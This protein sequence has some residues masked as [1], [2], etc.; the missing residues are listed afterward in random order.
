M[1]WLFASLSA[2]SSFSLCRLPT[3]TE[4]SVILFGKWKPVSSC[5]FFDVSLPLCVFMWCASP[6]PLQ[7]LCKL[8]H[9]KGLHTLTLIRHPWVKQNTTN[10]IAAICFLSPDAIIR[11]ASWNH[12]SL[13]V[14]FVSIVNMNP[15]SLAY[16]DSR[17]NGGCLAHT[18]LWVPYSVLHK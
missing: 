8:V 3:H 15:V 7:D 14:E 13:L 5:E 4:R 10:T 16:R 2:S 11:L 18:R 12:P 9:M 17:C 6:I 1:P